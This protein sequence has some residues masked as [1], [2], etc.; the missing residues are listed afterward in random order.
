[1]SWLARACAAIGLGL[2]N[3]ARVSAGNGINYVDFQ[4]GSPKCQAIKRIAHA[5]DLIDEAYVPGL[6]GIQWNMHRILCQSSQ[7]FPAMYF[8]LQK[9]ILDP[10]L[11]NLNPDKRYL[12]LFGEELKKSVLPAG[13]RING[14]YFRVR[15]GLFGERAFMLDYDEEVPLLKELTEEEAVPADHPMVLSRVVATYLS[16]SDDYIIQ[17]YCLLREELQKQDGPSLF[18][19]FLFLEQVMISKATLPFRF[20]DADLSVFTHAGELIGLDR[21]DEGP[22]A[23]YYGQAGFLVILLLQV[24]LAYDSEIIEHFTSDGLGALLQDLR[25]TEQPLEESNLIARA[26]ELLG[27]DVPLIGTRTLQAPLEKILTMESW[28]RDHIITLNASFYSPF[29]YKVDLG[30]MPSMKMLSFVITKD[31][32]FVTKTILVNGVY[33]FRLFA[34]IYYGIHT[35][36]A[37]FVSRIGDYDVLSVEPPEVERIPDAVCRKN[38]DVQL[39]PGIYFYKYHPPAGSKSARSIVAAVE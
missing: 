37:V 16:N 26:Y 15:G 31:L 13:I 23:N 39:G 3:L 10:R 2:L 1:M 29:K 35:P 17:E 8:N 7:P 14:S 19:E 36:R 20:F 4:D 9:L 32:H 38:S 34:Y 27:K 33:E 24:F 18:Y 22:Y 11:I 25:D 28:L 21:Q 12:L 6:C 5:L 30:E